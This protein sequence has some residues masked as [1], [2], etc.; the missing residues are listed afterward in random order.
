MGKSLA[1]LQEMYAAIQ[2]VQRDLRAAGASAK[3]RPMK[4]TADELGRLNKQ[5][6][7]AKKAERGR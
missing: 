6:E 5:I 4:Q 3:D 1:E 2:E 7:K